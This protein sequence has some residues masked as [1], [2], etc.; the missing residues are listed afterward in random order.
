MLISPFGSFEL[1]S[2]TLSAWMAEKGLSPWDNIDSYES[3]LAEI[4]ANDP[5]TKAE[6]KAHAEWAEKKAA[7]DAAKVKI[8]AATTG[9]LDRETVMDLASKILKGGYWPEILKDGTLVIYKGDQKIVWSPGANGW[10]T[11]L[12]TQ[13]SREDAGAGYGS[14]Q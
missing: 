4:A 3:E 1:S 5:D 13:G 6:I 14:N 2:I 8:I 12:S 10:S 9:G 7:D 11:I